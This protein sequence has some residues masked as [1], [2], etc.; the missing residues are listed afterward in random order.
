[1]ITI[2]QCQVL[3]YILDKGNYSLIISNNLNEDYFSDYKSE[4]N[5]IKYHVDQYGNVPDKE[6]FVSTFPDFDILKVN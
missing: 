6:T 2:I 4:F 5:Y 1:M 3:N